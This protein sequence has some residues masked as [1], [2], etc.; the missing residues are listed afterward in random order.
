[1]PD[2]FVFCHFFGFA[3]VANYAASV[4]E[5]NVR[6]IK[7]IIEHFKFD[8]LI[9]DQKEY[10]ETFKTYSVIVAGSNYHYD[11]EAT[12]KSEER[13]KLILRAKKLQNKA[14][15]KI[16][17][18]EKGKKTIEGFLKSGKLSPTF[19]SRYHRSVKPL[20]PLAGTLSVIL[21]LLS[22][23]AEIYKGNS[24]QHTCIEVILVNSFVI[25]S[26]TFIVLTICNFKIEKIGKSALRRSIILCIILSS[27]ALISII[28]GIIVLLFPKYSFRTFSD[29]TLY[30]ILFFSII[31]C[32][33]PIITIGYKM[34]RLFLSSN[35][36]R[37]EFLSSMKAC[38]A[39]MDG[40]LE[41]QSDFETEV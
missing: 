24:I 26:I 22:C 33:T 18:V 28:P 11:G 13:K 35:K 19:I 7:S 39:L 15:E 14:A 27:V 5:H 31:L 1:M 16:A 32:G 12:L 17:V 38:D 23:F 40:S 37:N 9:I 36:R 10:Y 2:I 34:V 41:L 25:I 8:A 20:F 4:F 30:I 6:I 21:L 3:A 29:M